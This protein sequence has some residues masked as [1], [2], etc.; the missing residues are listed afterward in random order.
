MRARPF[1]LAGL[2]VAL[3]ALAAY[4]VVPGAIGREHRRA[5]ARAAAIVAALRDP[6]GATVRPP[7]ACVLGSLRCLHVTR[8]A[9]DVVAEMA[10]ALRAASGAEPRVQC[11][12]EWTTRSA[13]LVRCILA[14]DTGRGH[15][16]FVFVDTAIR[17]VRPWS[18]EPDGTDVGVSS[19]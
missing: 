18:V 10:A 13:R 3:L 7:H 17:V 12:T 19:D 11:D 1:Y 6:A 4:L 14:A 2:A 5:E 16:V 9:G 8:D 15:G